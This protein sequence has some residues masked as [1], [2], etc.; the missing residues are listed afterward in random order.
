M[1]ASSGLC[2]AAPACAVRSNI[3]D[4]TQ[5][6]LDT[7]A[8]HA[9]LRKLV[10]RSVSPPSMVNMNMAVF[11]L[12]ALAQQSSLLTIEV[13]ETVFTMQQ[14]AVA[15][16]MAGWARQTARTPGFLPRLL[17]VGG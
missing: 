11:R 16:Q 10:I 15:M 7:L 5:D 14:A 4:V 13:R 2:I 3:K 9:A 6:A 1:L 12:L 17:F 8:G